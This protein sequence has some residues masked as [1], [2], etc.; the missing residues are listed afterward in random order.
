MH[1]MHL[2]EPWMETL[3]KGDPNQ[4][5]SKETI[6]ITRRT[7]TKPPRPRKPRIAAVA[8]DGQEEYSRQASQQ[9]LAWTYME[10]NDP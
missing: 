2:D 9:P 4:Y 5:H 10:E 3:Q 6:Q 7:H 1:L 8:D